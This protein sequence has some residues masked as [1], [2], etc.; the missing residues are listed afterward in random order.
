MGDERSSE[1]LG[2]GS[3]ND[4]PAILHDPQ[5]RHS[6]GLL[7]AAAGRSGTTPSREIGDAVEYYPPPDPGCIPRQRVGVSRGHLGDQEM[8]KCLV[9]GDL[10]NLLG[11]TSLYRF[12]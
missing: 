4:I 7:H 1:V 3:P 11:P 6:S 12:A 10:R 5:A 2:W 8:H 9:F